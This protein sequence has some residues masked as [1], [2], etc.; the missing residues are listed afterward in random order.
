MH[1][2]KECRQKDEEEEED[3]EDVEAKEAATDTKAELSW[4]SCK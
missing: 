2:A 4:A 1:V 3:V